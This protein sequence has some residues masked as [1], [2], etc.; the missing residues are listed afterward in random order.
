MQ[1]YPNKNR[2]TA[3]LLAVSLACLAVAGCSVF[4]GSEKEAPLAGERIPVMLTSAALNVDARIA[5][6]DVELPRPIVNVNWPQQGGNANH[7]MHHLALPESLGVAWR[8]DAGRGSSEEE[9][10]LSGPVV[11][12]GQIYVIDANATVSAF[13]VGEGDLSW[14]TELEPDGERDGSWG[15][16]LAY[17]G[18]RLFVTTGF[19]QVIALDAASGEVLWRTAVSGPMRAAPA[20]Y[21]GRVFA[22]TKDNQLHA[23]DAASGQLLWS[24]TGIVESVGLLGGAS[25]A[26]EG[27]IVIVPYSSGEIFAL[28]AQNGRELWSENLAA[29]RRLDS[30]SALSDIRGRPVIDRGRVYAIS[31]SGRMFAI[32]LRSGRRVWEAEIGGVEQPW[33]AGDYIY[34][35]STDA[36][37]AC[38]TARD[39]RVRWVTPIG[40]FKN[41][42]D[43]EGRRV[44][45]G[46]VVAGDRLI[47]AGG[48]GEALSLSPFTGEILGNIK[49]PG[50]VTVPMAV[51]DNT[52][53]L[54][55]DAAELVALR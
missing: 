53:Y 19:A 35:L 4:G 12:G 3:K 1:Q 55:S 22:V 29:V 17:D 40:L 44:W 28:R 24:H 50:G 9:R 39:G 18:G 26:V 32:D 33:I 2:R 47:V 16:G 49:T 8:A 46:P 48:H 7:A 5:D 14:R 20:A 37:V 11:A 52:L 45:T 25:P 31:H 6:L 38:I 43:Q 42:D 23:L 36:I 10:I 41:P 34:V 15:G 27:D 13:A 51:A 54:L 21:D 30:M